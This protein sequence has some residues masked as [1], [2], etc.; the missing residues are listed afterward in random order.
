MKNTHDRCRG[1]PTPASLCSGK[2]LCTHLC[3]RLHTVAHM[4]APVVVEFHDAADELV[5]LP[6]SFRTLH[7]VE[8]LLL[9][10]AV[11]A[12]GDGIVRRA[13]VLR[14]ADIDT[15]SVKASHILVAAVLNAAV[16]VVYE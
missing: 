8:P 14:H 10:D 12:L 16:R 7:A 6:R 9:D 13:V 5:C 2:A 3:G 4:R 1:A 15:Q 11:D